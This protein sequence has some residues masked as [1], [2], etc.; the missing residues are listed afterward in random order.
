MRYAGMPSVETPIPSSH[1]TS[2]TDAVMSLPDLLRA[3]SAQLV[4]ALEL[5]APLGRG[6]F[7][8]VYKGALAQPHCLLR[9]PLPGP[10]MWTAPD[11]ACSSPSARPASLCGS[12]HMR[13][14]PP[15]RMTTGWSAGKWRGTTVAVKII[16]H[17]AESSSGIK[18][19]RESVLSS[20]IIHPN[21][22]S[23]YKIRTIPAVCPKS[24]QAYPEVIL[25]SLASSQ[26]TD[27]AVRTTGSQGSAA[28]GGSLMV[29]FQE[30]CCR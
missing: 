13:L 12:E 28:L 17:S 25:P 1:N 11:W 5:G 18:E 2:V 9:K 4:G 24:C 8:K 7:G 22:V 20:S 14:L 6:S 16:E 26:S 3:R 10:F 19:L 23:T 15:P 29:R 30:V 27:V 21:V